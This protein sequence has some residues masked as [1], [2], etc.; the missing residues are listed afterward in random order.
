MSEPAKKRSKK[1][2]KKKNGDTLVNNEKTTAGR[3][4]GYQYACV[5]PKR[6]HAFEYGDT[7]VF[8]CGST[9]IVQDHTA[10]CKDGCDAHRFLMDTWQRY[11]DQTY[12]TDEGEKRYPPP[13]TFAGVAKV[14]GK[15]GSNFGELKSQNDAWGPEK[16]IM[17]F[18]ATK[19]KVVP[20]RETFLKVWEDL[21][22]SEKEFCLRPDLPFPKWK[23]IEEDDGSAVPLIH[24]QYNTHV[25][26]LEFVLQH[27]L[28]DGKVTQEYINKCLEEYGI[29]KKPDVLVP[30]TAVCG[31]LHT[32]YEAAAA[33]DMEEA[34]EQ[35]Q[36]GAPNAQRMNCRMR[37]FEYSPYAKM[38]KHSH[39]ND[40]EEG[41][42]SGRLFTQDE[43][44]SN[45]VLTLTNGE[46]LVTNPDEEAP[47]A[48]K[49][50]VAR[51]KDAPEA[52]RMLDFDRL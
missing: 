36:F 28:L 22:V 20:S 11:L 33:I 18:D 52:R 13:I 31:Q 51:V 47:G 43:R 16:P 12:G 17:Q 45:A 50:F 27:A 23:L 46:T 26:A 4:L 39:G 21:T 30:S 5:N 35:F 48:V 37:N 10:K 2:T 14:L 15:M 9:S 19:N 8:P 38:Y 40:N 25:E 7:V 34:F 1:V 6:I 24:R 49:T 29:V 41:M 42:E 3:K 32:K 44:K